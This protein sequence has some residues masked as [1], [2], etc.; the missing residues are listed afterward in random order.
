MW[1]VSHI[2]FLEENLRPER[3]SIPATFASV[4][5]ANLQLTDGVRDL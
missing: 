3:E 4:W 1:F 5:Q 2:H